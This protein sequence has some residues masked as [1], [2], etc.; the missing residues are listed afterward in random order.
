M[1]GVTKLFNVH[2]LAIIGAQIG[3]SLAYW[4]V[5]AIC[6]VVPAIDFFRSEFPFLWRNVPWFRYSLV[7]QMAI[8][9][10]F[11]LLAL[12][13]QAPRFGIVGLVVGMVWMLL[14]VKGMYGYCRENGI[15]TRD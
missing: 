12:A 14:H 6:V 11:G 8:Q 7:G 9:L 10:T 4:Q 3:L 5:V 13:K 1:F 2:H 15:P